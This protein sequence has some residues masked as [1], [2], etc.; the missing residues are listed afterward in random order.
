[1]RSLPPLPPLH[2]LR[3]FHATARFGRIKEAADALG[4]T[5]SAVSHQVRKLEAWL[6]IR[7]FDRNGPQ[8]RL[9]DDGRR[10]YA[11]IDP[12]FDTIRSATDALKTPAGR[13]RVSITLPASLATYW[14]IPRLDTLDKAC[15]GV[16][17][18]LVT[19]ARLVD[20][21][22]EGVD[23]AIRHGAGGWP[24]LTARRLMGEQLVPV[25]R[26][27]YVAPVE[28][29]DPATVLANKRLIVNTAYPQHW[30][31]WAAANGLPP[32]PLAGA[33]RFSET[34]Q[35]LAAAEGGLG[36]AMGPR[37]MVDAMLEARSLVAPFGGAGGI[38]NAAFWL[39]WPKDARQT[40][41]ARKVA[42]WLET[43]AMRAVASGDAVPAAEPA[44]AP[45]KPR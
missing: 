36:L 19:T 26:P 43:L 4:L 22:R 40:V 28:A 37:P 30:A 12:A 1:M 31:E 10:F 33:L 2:A 41:A 24:E 16:D 34:E 9:N 35:I 32:P 25:C 5:E 23:L 29:R 39:A 45:K 20:L 15:P 21:R 3:A 44:K 11:A 17:L 38:G 14:L 27:G 8:I 6:S 13:N 42:R 18:E 7:L